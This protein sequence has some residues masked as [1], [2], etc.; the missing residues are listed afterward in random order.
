[1]NSRRFGSALA[2]S[3]WQV[4]T[5]WLRPASEQ[6]GDLARGA[7]ARSILH[8]DD[9]AVAETESLAPLEPEPFGV[10][11]VVPDGEAITIRA[12]IVHVEVAIADS[13]TPLDSAF[14]N[15]PGLVDASSP[16]ARAPE[17]PA[18][19]PTAPHDAR[20]H[21]CDQRLDVAVCES[22]VRLPDRLHVRAR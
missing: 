21:Q 11:P 8:L 15:R 12:N 5:K 3:R 22:L 20:M 19:T 4:S 10:E 14:E 17:A 9:R 13:L 7:A 16:R 2:I 1:M 6:R 18:W